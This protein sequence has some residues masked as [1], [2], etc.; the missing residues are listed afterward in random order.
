[1]RISQRDQQ[2]RGSDRK[3]EKDGGKRDRQQTC[4]KQ[5]GGERGRR[6]TTQDTRAK[7]RRKKKKV[8]EFRKKKKSQSGKTAVKDVR[9]RDGRTGDANEERMATMTG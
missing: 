8:L 2:R 7:N 4:E 6:D 1:M 3:T 5:D 9:V